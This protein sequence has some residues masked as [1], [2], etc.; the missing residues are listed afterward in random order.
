MSA[1]VL[2]DGD[3]ALLEQLA[4]QLT[5]QASQSGDLAVTTDGTTSQIRSGAQWSGSAADAYTGFTTAMSR[6]LGRTAAP[7]AGIAAAV[8]GYAGYLRT[9]QERADAYNVAVRQAQASGGDPASLQAAY[10]AQADAAAASA[11][12]QDAGQQAATQVQAAAVTLDG[13]FA[14]EGA[15]RSTIEE[16]HTLLGAAGADGALWALSRGAEQAKQFLDELPDLEREWLH[17]LVPWD[18]DA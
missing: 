14:P 9:A 1:P 17:D 7:L 18:Q 12:L 4:G 6:G 3:P 2:P 13:V 8:R 10:S 15:L 16:I 5:Q 11:Q